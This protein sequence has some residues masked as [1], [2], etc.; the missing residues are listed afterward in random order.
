YATH[1]N[2]VGDTWDWEDSQ[3]YFFDDL[4][5]V[6]DFNDGTTEGWIATAGTLINEG[7][8]YLKFVRGGASTMDEIY[9]IET[10]D[11]NTY[12]NIAFE[13]NSSVAITFI[14]VWD[15]IAGENLVCNDTTGWTADTWHLFT[16]TLTGNWVGSESHLVL[17][18]NH[19]SADA[20]YFFNM[21]YLY[22]QELGDLEGWNV[23][24]GGY[25]YTMPEGY[26]AYKTE[27]AGQ[28]L[29]KV[30]G[31]S[32]DTSIFD[33]LKVRIKTSTG[34]A[35]CYLRAGAGLL[36]V[37]TAM[38]LTTSFQIFIFDLNLDADWTSTITQLVFRIT[39][40]TNNTIIFDYV[41]LE[42]S[43]EREQDFVF[44]F[45]DLIETNVQA[46]VNITH[47]F[48]N[49]TTFR[50][51]IELYDSN[52]EIASFFYSSNQTVADVYYSVSIDYN[53]LESEFKTTIT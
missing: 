27:G 50:W 42:S 8:E 15:E 39:G 52:Q 3:E 40:G 51:E 18:I 34:T 26:H 17:N 20:T 48:F 32:I 43:T 5:N 14:E 28:S 6:S 38:S 23:F 41:L 46:L 1:E 11:A 2:S 24:G 49:S 16:C 35:T 47:H 31:L 37:T 29:S 25:T 21:I 44:G 33:T 36:D 22:D 13:F 10:I 4:G 45:W 53:I 30:A 9:R 7:S 12:N 19:A